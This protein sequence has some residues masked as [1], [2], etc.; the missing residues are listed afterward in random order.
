MSKW[1]IIHRVRYP[2][3]DDKRLHA[4]SVPISEK[5]IETNLSDEKIQL[6]LPPYK[7]E[8]EEGW[9][10]QRLIVDENGD[11]WSESTDKRKDSRPF[12]QL[13]KEQRRGWYILPNQL[14]CTFK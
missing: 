9:L 14:H 12:V 1:S 13:V 3:F 10:I 5:I 11:E 7:I 6:E 2:P 8:S 4:D